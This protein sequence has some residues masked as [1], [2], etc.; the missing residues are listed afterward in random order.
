MD[1]VLV[2]GFWLDGASWGDVAELL[3]RAGHRVHAVT[4]P[5]LESLDADRRGITLQDHVDAVV[6]VVDRCTGD[7]VLVGHSGGGAITYA[8]A[9]A[10][11]DRVARVVYVDSAP[12]PAGRPINDD[13]PVVDGEIPLPDW[14]YF[15]DA[16][17]R[18]L[19]E[20]L[21]Q[22]FRARALPEP[23]RV[24]YDGLVLHDERRHD[25]PATVVCCEFSSELLRGWLAEGHPMVAE[26]AEV[27]DVELVDLP[28]GHWPQF[29]K[30]T[31][32]ADVVLRAVEAHRV[33]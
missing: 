17:L 1:L 6:D 10:R 25:V 15:T 7:V 26:L 2:L 3:G 22:A 24:A 5:G 32:L 13:L 31:Q 9:D 18:D 21:R 19:D 27:R 16:D 23:A 30:P 4:L 33:P 29:T 20:P 14:S 11:P 28:T 12:L 8:V